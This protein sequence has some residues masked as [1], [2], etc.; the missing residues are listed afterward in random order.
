MGNG[1]IA[2]LDAEILMALLKNPSGQLGPLWT[3]GGDQRR[4]GGVR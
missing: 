2:D 1:C 3:E 4:G